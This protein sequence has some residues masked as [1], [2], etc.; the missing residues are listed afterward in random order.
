MR[1][2]YFLEEHVGPGIEAVALGFVINYRGYSFITRRRQGDYLQECF[3]IP[4]GLLS[5]GNEGIEEAAKR[6]LKKDYGLDLVSI[7]YFLSAFTFVSPKKKRTRQFNFVVSV[8]SPERVKIDRNDHGLW[9]CKEEMNYWPIMTVIRD[10]MVNYWVGE[11]YSPLHADFLIESAKAEDVWRHKVRLIPIQE[12]MVLLLKRS[13]RQKTLPLYY[14][15]PGK[16]VPSGVDM[17]TIIVEA[18]QEQTGFPPEA[19]VGY[20]GHYDYV[21]SENFEKVREFIYFVAAQKDQKVKLSTH[22]YAFWTKDFSLKKVEVTPCVHSAMALL[23]KR[24]ILGKT[25]KQKMPA[26]K[27]CDPNK[28]PRSLKQRKKMDA[29]A[30]MCDTGKVD[31]EA[32][33]GQVLVQRAFRGEKE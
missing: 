29:W 22:A 2:N 26:P 19:I 28:T 33:D 30:A 10:A 14:E 1:W 4:V 23:N 32:L 11:G 18:M 6:I 17:D 25:P 5:L 13:R 12:R 9:M 20:V 15:F 31:L 7:D 16:E 24:F 21:S 27:Y 8:A 3:E